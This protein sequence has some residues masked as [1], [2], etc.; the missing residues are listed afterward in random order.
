MVV[1]FTKPFPRVEEGTEA[2]FTLWFL[3]CIPLPWVARH[4][5]VTDNGFVDE[6][7]E[8][9]LDSWRHEHRFAERSGSVHVE[10]TIEYA[11]SGLLSR[12]LFNQA[13]LRVLFLY[14]AFATRRA[15]AAEAKDA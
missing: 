7:V 14:R 15:L 4:S 8:G 5:R 9:P 10:D 2:S 6:M 11:H 13:A 12:V 1:T 3:G